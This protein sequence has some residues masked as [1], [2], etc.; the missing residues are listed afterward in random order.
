MT[1]GIYLKGDSVIER[2]KSV[3]NDLVEQD[4][5]VILEKAINNYCCAVITDNT[6]YELR[7]VNLDYRNIKQD[8]AYFDVYHTFEELKKIINKDL[9]ETIELIYV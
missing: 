3:V 7:N 2:F 1:I 6:V 5:E 9:A 8:K 4:D